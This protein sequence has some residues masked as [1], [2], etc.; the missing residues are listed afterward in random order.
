M[1]IPSIKRQDRGTYYCNAKN[2]VGEPDQ[3]TIN[4]EVEF[5]PAISVPRPKVAQALKYDIELECR[6]EAYPAPAIIWFKDDKQILSED[7]YRWVSRTFASL[8]M[9]I[10][11]IN[12]FSF[13]SITNVGTVDEVTTSVLRIRA[14]ES[15]QYGD[16]YCKA[17]NKCGHSE[18]RMNLFGKII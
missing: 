3:K 9:A 16:Y 1:I 4:L 13:C 5:S 7:V 14:I 18:A 17:N 11:Q 12:R 6:A 2:G 8:F 15:S 10:N